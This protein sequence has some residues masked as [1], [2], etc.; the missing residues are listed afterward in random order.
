MNTTGLILLTE[1]I[2]IQARKDY[3]TYYGRDPWG[4]RKT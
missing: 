2:L 4:S 3:I 1:A